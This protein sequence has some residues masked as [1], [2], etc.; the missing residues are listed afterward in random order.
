MACSSFLFPALMSLKII[1]TKTKTTEIVIRSSCNRS[2][3]IFWSSTSRFVKL[4]AVCCG[5]WKSWEPGETGWVA[6]R[7]TDMLAYLGTR[8]LSFGNL[9][10]C[11][12]WIQH[13]HALLLNT[14]IPT[15]YPFSRNEK[16]HVV[17]FQQD[18]SDSVTLKSFP[19]CVLFLLYC[20]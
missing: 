3:W 13:N 6:A 12:W 7:Q 1:I 20:K 4:L 10:C 2:G 11:F 17:K 8:R 14:L 19:K 16:Y 9:P 18:V 5:V 15:N